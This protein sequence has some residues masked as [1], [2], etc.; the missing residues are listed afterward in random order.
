MIQLL[1]AL[2]AAEAALALSL[3]FRTPARRLALLAIDRAKRGRGPV[4]ARTVA[5][6]MLL[7]LASAG[8]S[9]AKIRR[10][11]GSS[12]SSRPPTR[13]SPAATSS[14]PRSWD[15]LCFLD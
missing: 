14:R 12:G 10:H 13:C 1:F 2:L 9:I 7:V 6:T 5:A 8:Y 3:L 11:A 4:M 15:I